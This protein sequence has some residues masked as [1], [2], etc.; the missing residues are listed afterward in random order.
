MFY[1]SIEN[2]ISVDDTFCLFN[3]LFISVQYYTVTF[4]F[5]KWITH[6]FVTHENNKDLILH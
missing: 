2:I 3:N 6:H 4:N 5:M 1:K